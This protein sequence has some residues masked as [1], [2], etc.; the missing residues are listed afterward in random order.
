MHLF[1]VVCGSCSPIDNELI[2]QCKYWSVPMRNAPPKEKPEA[3]IQRQALIRADLSAAEKA[4]HA[5]Q[6]ECYDSIRTWFF[7][8]GEPGVPTAG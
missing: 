6:K 5:A 3:A 8:I 4:Y 7:R 1:F 2:L